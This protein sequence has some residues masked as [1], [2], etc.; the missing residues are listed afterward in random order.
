MK[1]KVVILATGGTI[2]SSG[3][4][5]AQ[6]TGYSIRGLTVG[7]VIRAVPC[8]ED[9]ADIEARTVCSIPSSSIT[10]KIW[11]ALAAQVE[12]AC[13]RDD[14]AGV[15]VTHGTDTMEETAF[16]LNLV[17][18]T[19]KPV[20][21]TGAMRPATALSADGPINLLNAV[22]VAASPEALGKGVLIVMNGII[23]GARDTTKTH[24][25]AVDTFRG[26]DFGTFGYVIGGETAFFTASVRPHTLTSEFSLADFRED[27]DLPRTALITAHAEEDVWTVQAALEAGVRGIVYA[28]C[29]HGTVSAAMETELVRAAADGIAVVRASRTGAGPV[30]DGLPRWQEAGFIPAGTLPPQKARILLQLGLHRFGPD[31]DAL[32]HLFK[33]Y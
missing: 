5:A 20:V 18:K 3:D 2:V 4:S 19:A 17:L 21:L 15:V 29:G 24:T 7:D 27:A 8:L 1:P 6:M 32:R 31:R 9:I 14:V 30:L 11:I 13:R 26:R 16:F 33:T 23:G 10:S 28:G 12:E 25:T 22:R